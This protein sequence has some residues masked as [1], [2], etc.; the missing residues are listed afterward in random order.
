MEWIPETEPFLEYES[1]KDIINESIGT[2]TLNKDY[3]KEF[4]EKVVDDIIDERYKQFP[5]DKHYSQD[6]FYKI[7]NEY[8]KSYN[9]YCLNYHMDDVI[10]DLYYN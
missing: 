1:L 7:L 5:I 8:D 3:T 10:D 4:I 6:F 2:I 9:I